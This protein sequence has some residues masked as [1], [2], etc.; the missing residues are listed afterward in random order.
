MLKHLVHK[1]VVAGDAVVQ[2]DTPRDADTRATERVL[3]QGLGEVGDFVGLRER[4]VVV[5]VLS[6]DDG[7]DDRCVGDRPR[8][9]T[10]RVLV[11]GD[12]YDC[13]IGSGCALPPECLHTSSARSESDRRFNSG[14]VV[15]ARWARYAPVGLRAQRDRG[16]ADGRSDAGAR[17]RATRVRVREVCICCLPA[18][19]RPAGREI[20]AEVRPL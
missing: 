10:D 19:A 9:W 13:T 11:L 5:R 2:K 15:V 14:K 17:G 12:R 16:K 20:A 6:G 8:Y 4:E 18:S 1:R 7:E 3:V